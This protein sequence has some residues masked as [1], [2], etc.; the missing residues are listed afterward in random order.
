MRIKNQALELRAGGDVDTEFTHQFMQNYVRENIR[1]IG[2]VMPPSMAQPLLNSTNGVAP[3][4]ISISN[5]KRE[6]VYILLDQ[7]EPNRGV[8]YV[9]DRDTRTGKAETIYTRV[10]PRG[11]VTVDGGKIYDD[12]RLDGGYLLESLQ[13]LQPD[14][15]D[16]EAM[17]VKAMLT[18]A[19]GVDVKSHDGGVS[20]LSDC[21][22]AR[23][24]AEIEKDNAKGRDEEIC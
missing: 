11:I 10:D 6:P 9:Q 22:A 19:E 13:K 15:F 17:S 2:K 8:I 12:Y 24:A 3:D 5:D 18:I 14:K 21:G 16:L 23:A 20:Y 7:N 1:R 4:Y